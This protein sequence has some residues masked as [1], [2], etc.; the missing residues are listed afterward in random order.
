MFMEPSTGKVGVVEGLAAKETKARLTAAAE[1]KGFKG[2]DLNDLSFRDFIEILSLWLPSLELDLLVLG[3][4]LASEAEA[5]FA[6]LGVDERF[7]KPISIVFVGTVV[8]EVTNVVTSHSLEEA[9]LEDMN[10][11]FRQV[12]SFG[13]NQELFGIDRAFLE[14]RIVS[15]RRSLVASFHRE[16]FARLKA[17]FATEEWRRVEPNQV[18]IA[19]LR[20]LSES[21][22]TSFTLG[23][24]TYGASEPVLILLELTSQYLEIAKSISVWSNDL[25]VQLFENVRFFMDGISATLLDPVRQV[26]PG[27]LALSAA[28]LRFY[29]ELVGFIEP[30]FVKAGAEETIADAWFSKMT[31]MLCASYNAVALRIEDGFV[32]AIEMESGNECIDVSTEPKK[33]SRLIDEVLSRNRG[34][35][36]CLPPF[37]RNRIFGE[38]RGRLFEMYQLPPRSDVETFLQS[39]FTPLDDGCQVCGEIDGPEVESWEF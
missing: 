16:Y 1:Q 11:L 35:L 24:D 26:T 17:A 7:P 6:G 4:K 29:A 22:V 10:E 32:E 38:T 21:N 18:H 13:V 5:L 39:H 36:E 33:A 8:R 9:S 23:Y 2:R 37:L 30:M 12:V 25:V 19:I 31:K 3:T 27:T 20:Q 15:L 34:I 14:D 28:G